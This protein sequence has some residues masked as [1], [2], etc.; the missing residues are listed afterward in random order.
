MPAAQILE[1][2]SLFP[3]YLVMLQSSITDQNRYQVMVVVPHGGTTTVTKATGYT[4]HKI[5]APKTI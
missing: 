3:H 5:V 4:A 2:L 1:Y